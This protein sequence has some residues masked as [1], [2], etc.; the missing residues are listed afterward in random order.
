LAPESSCLGL[1]G[2]LCPG[3]FVEDRGDWL[4]GIDGNVFPFGDAGNYG[5]TA[6]QP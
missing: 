5:N 4:F 6:N 2:V 1:V 3:P